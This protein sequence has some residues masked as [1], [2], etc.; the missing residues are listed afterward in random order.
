LTPNVLT[1]YGVIAAAVD[2]PVGA[3]SDTVTATVTF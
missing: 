3:Y 1:T 2:V